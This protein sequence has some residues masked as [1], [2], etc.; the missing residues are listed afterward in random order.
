MTL[1]PGFLRQKGPSER[2]LR[3]ANMATRHN[4]SNPPA[5]PDW[6]KETVCG[7]SSY[8]RFMVFLEGKKHSIIV[9]PGHTEYID[10]GS[11]NGYCPTEYT[12][13]EKGKN[14]WS[15][16]WIRVHEGRMSKDQRSRLEDLL[17]IA[18]KAGAGAVKIAMGIE[19]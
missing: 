8:W 6:L 18:E 5:Q 15:H 7:L 3:G 12:L 1:N 10:R 14:Y 11:G 4:I 9:C 13:V 16:T 19:T 2:F 17:A